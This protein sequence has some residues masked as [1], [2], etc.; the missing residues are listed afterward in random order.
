MEQAVIHV[1][2]GISGRQVLAVLASIPATIAA[3]G[4][5]GIL[6]MPAK[7]QD[8]AATR[9]Q[10]EV[11]SRQLDAA[12]HQLTQSLANQEE[13]RKTVLELTGAV[14]DLQDVVGQVRDAPPKVIIREVRTPAQS[15]PGVKPA[16][17]VTRQ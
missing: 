10:I 17:P 12:K 1:N 11:T 14:R 2:F 8:L 3:L 15:R 7:E 16:Q 13:I 9:A 6:F 4:T 5:A